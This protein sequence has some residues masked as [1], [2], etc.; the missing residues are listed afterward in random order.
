LNPYIGLRG[1]YARFLGKNEALLGGLLGLE[2][3]KGEWYIIDAEVR[4]SALFG[5]D[6]GGHVG[7][8]PSLGASIA[9]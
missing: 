1:G 2:L 8:E 7:V 9:F 4:A 3:V 6:A 5:S